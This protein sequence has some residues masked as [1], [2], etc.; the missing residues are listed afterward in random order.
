LMRP[1]KVIGIGLNKTGTKSLAAC[2]KTLGYKKNVSIRRDLLVQYKNGY[3]EDIFKVVDENETF[4]DWP[5]PLIYKELF[6]RYGDNARYIL[7]KRKDALSW[8]DS[9]KR[10]SLTTPPDEHCRLLSFGYNYPHGLETYHLDFYCRHNSDVAAFFADQN[11]TH[12]LLEASWDTGDGW[13]KICSFLGQPV[14]VSG[15]PHENRGTQQIPEDIRKENLARINKQLRSL[16]IDK[17]T[18]I[19]YGP[20]IGRDHPAP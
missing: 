6:F 14:P 8:L 7:T 4:E 19:A 13:E 9:L 15:F 20:T 3:L 16:Y 18:S 2:L 5:F 17:Y 1:L 11:A 12:L 10:H